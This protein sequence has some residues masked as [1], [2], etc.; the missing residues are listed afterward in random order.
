Q[1]AEHVRLLRGELLG[2]PAGLASH[3]LDRLGGG[4]GALLLELLDRA[5]DLGARLEHVL[6]RF[7]PAL[8]LH[9][10]LTLAHVVLATD[11]ASDALARV[12]LHRRGFVLALLELLL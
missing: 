11:D 6:A 7:L 2:A 10:A 8:F 4:G 9:R 3:F 1:P 12:V 5:L